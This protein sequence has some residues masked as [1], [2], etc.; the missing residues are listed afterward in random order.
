MSI[1]PFK[2]IQTGDFHLD[3]PPAG[4]ADLPEHLKSTLVD[5][6]YRA[7]AR[8]FEVA[9]SERVDFLLLAGDLL[10]PASAGPRGW[11]FLSEQFER[12]RQQ[13]ILVYWAT[14]RDDASLEWPALFP[15]PKNV[16]RFDRDGITRFVHERNGVPIAEICGLGYAP[17]DMVHAADFRPENEGLFTI[18]LAHGE[19]DADVA[20][21]CDDIDYWALGGDHQRRN[22]FTTPVTA[23]YA[24]SPQGRSPHESGPHG[25]TLVHVNDL[26][27]TESSFIPTDVVRFQTELVAG[28][29]TASR[30]VLDRVLAE[31]AAALAGVGPELL[32]TWIVVGRGAVVRQLRRGAIEAELLNRLRSEWGRRQPCALESRS[33]GRTARRR[34]RV[35]IRRT[36]SAWR[37]L[38]ITQR[39]GRSKPRAVGHECVLARTFFSGWRARYRS[40]RFGGVERKGVERCGTF[41]TGS[42]GCRRRHCAADSGRFRNPQWRGLANGYFPEQLVGQFRPKDRAT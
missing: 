7:A 32:I 16:E 5:A 12:L 13:G 3:R 4:I 17:R 39:P 36:V 14:G 33:S 35:A 41:G 37:I 29:D 26:G 24:G 19:I 15:L 42:A 2:F 34:S 10:H 40:R 38:A 25:C 23:H 9:L 27:Q 18:A 31:R 21:K 30:E 8:I 22:L 28:I 11:F 6:A 20:A 1:P